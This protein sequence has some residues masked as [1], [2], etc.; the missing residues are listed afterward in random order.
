MAHSSSKIPVVRSYTDFSV[1]EH[2][3]AAEA[4][5]TT[6]IADNRTGVDKDID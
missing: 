1:P 4:G 6:G 3:L 5:R 2:A